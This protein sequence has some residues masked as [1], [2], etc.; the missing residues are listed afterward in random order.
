MIQPGV[1]A[2]WHTPEH[3]RAQHRAPVA[4]KTAQREKPASLG[5]NYVYHPGWFIGLKKKIISLMQS[6]DQKKLVYKRLLRGVGRGGACY[7]KPFNVH[8]FISPLSPEELT[9][10]FTPQ[11]RGN[12]RPPTPC[13]A[14]TDPAPG[15]P[16]SQH[17]GLWL[18][19]YHGC[20]QHLH[21][22]GCGW[23]DQQQQRYR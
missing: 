19:L 6:S 11:V 8:Q 21:E 23:R 12:D 7:G 13:W 4:V 5:D 22:T 14:V 16:G 10:F 17:P 20:I 9:V 15:S 18:G 2:T 1:R 3:Q